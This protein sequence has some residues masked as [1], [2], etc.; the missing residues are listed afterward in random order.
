MR[1][2]ATLVAVMVAVV[3]AVGVA[4]AA[5]PDKITID[6]IKKTKAAVAYNHKVH[7]EKVPKCQACHHKDAAGKEQAC[8]SATCH[9]AQAEGTKLDL[10]EAFHKQC[11]ACHQKE[12]KGP[13]KCDECHPKG[14]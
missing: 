6:K 1:K 11:K 7:S 12:K 8:S 2:I 4:V 9:G 10:K 3:F 13:Q 5:P 14:K